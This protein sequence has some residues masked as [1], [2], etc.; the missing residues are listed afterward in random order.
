MPPL[1]SD[2]LIQILLG[3]HPYTEDAYI[4]NLASN[5]CFAITNLRQTLYKRPMGLDALLTKLLHQ[6]NFHNF[7]RD[8]PQDALHKI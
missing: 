1:R 5:A 3:T 7:G 4:Y 6:H 8:P 2:D